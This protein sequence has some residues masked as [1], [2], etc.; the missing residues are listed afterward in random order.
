MDVQFWVI[1]SCTFAG[2][3]PAKW[4][5]RCTER[6]SLSYEDFLSRLHEF[7]RLGVGM[8]LSPSP[9]SDHKFFC[10][11]CRFVKSWKAMLDGREK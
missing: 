8:N 9:S 4:N 3:F 5:R 1:G 10:G 11:L 6:K 2:G 7:V